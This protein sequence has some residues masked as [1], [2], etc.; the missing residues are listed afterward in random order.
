MFFF[1]RLKRDMDA[2]RTSVECRFLCSVF[3]SI[4][5][6]KSLAHGE[7]GVMGVWR[8]TRLVDRDVYRC[9]PA[10]MAY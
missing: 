10:I 8:V 6:E 3:V 5:I 1:F 9:T 4:V 2:S 7:R